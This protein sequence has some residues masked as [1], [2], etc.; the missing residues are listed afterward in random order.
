MEEGDWDKMSWKYE[1]FKGDMAIYAICPICNFHYCCGDFLKKQIVTQYTYC[2]MCG[3]YLYENTEE[4]NV[5]YN[6]NELDVLYE[7]ELNWEIINKE[8]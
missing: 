7:L 2:P 5:I 8:R 6:K 4:V 1:K 3:E